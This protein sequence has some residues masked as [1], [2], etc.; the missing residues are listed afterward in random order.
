MIAYW[1]RTSG[2]ATINHMHTQFQAKTGLDKIF[3]VGIL[4]KAAHGLIEIV[5]GML[6]L[7]VTPDHIRRIAIWLTQGELS[8]DPHDFIAT[9]ILHS[10]QGVTHGVLLFA[11]IYLLA[12][13]LI[14]VVLVVEILRNRLWAYPGLIIVTAGF[15]V[16]QLYQMLQIFSWW[17]LWLTI[18]DL[19]IIYLTAREYAGRRHHHRTHAESA[20]G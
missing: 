20:D 11:A 12:H 5:G 2:P 10:A 19:F 14:K 3:E 6:L 17:L 7:F 15:V 16:Y 18:F 9:H 8:Q 13:G 1:P 4:I